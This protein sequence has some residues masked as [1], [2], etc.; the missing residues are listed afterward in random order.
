MTGIFK[1]FFPAYNNFLH[2][3]QNSCFQR[4][5]WPTENC[6]ARF[7]SF[8]LLLIESVHKTAKLIHP[9]EVPQWNVSRWL[10]RPINFLKLPPRSQILPPRP[11]NEYVFYPSHNETLYPVIFGKIGG[12]HSNRVFSAWSWVFGLILQLG[13]RNSVLRVR[14]W[15]RD[16]WFL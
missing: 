11:I 9:V 15:I 8:T 7:I 3:S 2:I 12:P 4:M 16:I 6:L 1:V 13:C 14:W 10:P 5:K